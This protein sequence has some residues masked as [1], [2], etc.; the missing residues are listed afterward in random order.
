MCSIYCLG[1]QS[2]RR[3]NSQNVARLQT[4]QYYTKSENFIILLHITD[5]L[6]LLTKNCKN[7][8]KVLLIQW[9]PSTNVK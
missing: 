7:I 1:C 6:P 5:A 4:L 9:R 2:K 8:S 3:I